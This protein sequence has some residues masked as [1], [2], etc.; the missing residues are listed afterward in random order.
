MVSTVL[1]PQNLSQL[2]PG[3]LI[4]VPYS[5]E[6]GANNPDL[7]ARVLGHASNSSYFLSNAE[8]QELRDYF[9]K[10][11]QETNTGY[12][13]KNI[14]GEDYVFTNVHSDGRFRLISKGKLPEDE[15]EGSNGRQAVKF[16]RSSQPAVLVLNVE[17]D[18]FGSDGTMYPSGSIIT[19]RIFVPAG[20]DKYSFIDDV[21]V[22]LDQRFYNVPQTVYFCRPQAQSVPQISLDQYASLLRSG[23]VA[24]L[25]A[26][27][28][29]YY[30]TTSNGQ[31][32]RF[33]ARHNPQNNQLS[34]E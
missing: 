4:E 14:N 29:W 32:V 3:D 31:K 21:N 34:P 15:Y 2:Q 28:T 5:L 30:A 1:T 18:F 25:E 12:S 11:P 13:Y 19:G 22:P 33:R 17:G 24:N 26:E 8:I 6:L 10:F 20:S 23:Q 16:P 9:R 7:Y 27:P